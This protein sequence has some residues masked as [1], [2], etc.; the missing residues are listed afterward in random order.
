MPGGMRVGGNGIRFFLLLRRFAGIALFL[1]VTVPAVPAA[2][3][4]S[5]RGTEELM[6]LSLEELMQVEVT[7]VS[8][9]SQKV[10]DAAAAVFVITQEDIR[11][12][13]ATTIPDLLRMVPGLQV[14]RINASQWAVSAR[15]FNDRFSNKLL[16]LIDGRTVYTPLFSGVFWDSQDTMLEDIDRIEVIRGPG[17]TLW[18]ANAVNGV[19]NIITKSAA[20][21]VGGLAVAGGGSEERGFGTLRYGAKLGSETFGRIYAKYCDRGASELSSGGSAS[22]QWHGGRWGFRVDSRL[23]PRDTVTAQGDMYYG[24]NDQILNLASLT[25]PYS[26]QVD[27]ETP[28]FGGYALTRWRRTFSPTADLALQ[29]YFNHDDFHNLTIDDDRD[30]YDLDFQHRFAWGERQRIIWGG[31][32]RRTQDG[33]GPRFITY[34]DPPNRGDNLFS[35][36]LQDEIS[37]VGDELRFIAGSRFEHNDYTGFEVQPTGRLIW[38]PTPHVTFWGAVSRAVRTP[39][40][41]E[42]DGRINQP[43]IPPGG[44]GNPGT[45]PLLMSMIGDHDYTS[46][47]L[48]AYEIGHRMQVTPAFSYDLAAFYNVYHDLRTLEPGAPFVETSPP[49]AHTTAPLYLANKMNRD[50]FGVELAVDWRLREWWRLQGAYTWLK[51]ALHHTDQSGDTFSLRVEGDSPR[52]QLSLRSAMDL[53]WHLELDLWG[54]YVDSLPTQKIPSYVTF[55]ARLAW[56][57]VK[58]LEV[59]LVGRNLADSPHPEFVPELVNTIQT[60]VERS[61]YGKVTWR[62]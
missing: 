46:E 10:S 54:R 20:D 55:D 8:R 21:T 38:A 33:F 61:V 26:Q 53:P 62:F 41:A 42:A 52:N 35:F 45:T 51:L 19:I 17:A 28:I 2:G 48:I 60:E 30:T 1:A 34:A 4:S 59:A 49:P 15:G 47:E 40:R 9:T 32:Y 18:G 31:G 37:L 24:Q 16:V 23:T 56:K 50:A 3:D 13:G 57:P 39:S 58:S 12:S 11:R 6:A 44:P 29:L 36:F 25:P 43:V 14:A 22:D 27:D 7:S 5:P